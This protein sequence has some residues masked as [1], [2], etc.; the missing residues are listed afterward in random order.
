MI[1]SSQTLLQP[2]ND[3]IGYT[4]SVYNADDALKILGCSSIRL[5]GINWPTNAAHLTPDLR[6]PDGICPNPVLMKAERS[7]K[8]ILAFE[9]VHR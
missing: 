3:S 4:S 9:A 5:A 8:L 7:I 6:T 1:G 2:T